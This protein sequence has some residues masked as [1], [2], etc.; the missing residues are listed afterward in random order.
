MFRTFSREE[1][2]KHIVPGAR[3]SMTVNNGWRNSRNP[4]PGFITYD[5]KNVFA[6]YYVIITNR[7]VEAVDITPCMCVQDNKQLTDLL[8][9]EVVSGLVNL[10]NI[11]KAKQII[12]S[13]TLPNFADH[14]LDNEFTILRLP[15]TKD[16][17][18]ILLGR[19]ILQ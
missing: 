15:R 8:L 14:L 13:S 10:A 19:R 16:G 11:I 12:L 17:P 1:A 7:V 5:R 4:E 2:K 6:C 9:G 3:V 18:S